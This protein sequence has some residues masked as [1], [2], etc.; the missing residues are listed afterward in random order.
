M[1]RAKRLIRY[2][3]AKRLAL[4]GKG[5]A[6]AVLDSG[7]APHPDLAGR[8]VLFRDFTKRPRVGAYD[9][10]GHGTHINGILAG[11]GMMSG[12]RYA[13]MAPACSLINAKILDAAGEG[14][15]VSM[16]R[17]LEWLL[18]I[19]KEYRIRIVNLSVAIYH[20][21]DQKRLGEIYDML[22][23]VNERGIL[24]V[25]AAGN[26]GPGYDTISDIGQSSRV[27][28]IG[29]HDFGFKDSKGHSCDLRSGRGRRGT[30]IR[31]P[32]LV[33][34]GT[35]IYSC[36]HRPER[37]KRGVWGYTA[38]TGTSMSVPIVSG[39]AA[40]LMEQQPQLGAYMVKRKLQLG[41]TDLHENY[42][43]QGYGMLNMEKVL[44][45]A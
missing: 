19:E 33:A 3:C 1:D 37:R 13:G 12:G 17:A 16:L 9:D 41:T 38:K 21:D 29:C 25:T 31:K 39:A 2:A 27:L 42:A 5:V 6:I 44:D 20:M 32:D 10:C 14:D 22:E 8:N 7:I 11:N 26:F 43:K 15:C 18:R 30:E 35:E 23:R 40:L 45:N 28:T 34:P 24:I 36:A 4:S